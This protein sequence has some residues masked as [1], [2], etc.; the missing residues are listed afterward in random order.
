MSVRTGSIS[1]SSVHFVCFLQRMH[2]NENSLLLTKGK[3]LTAFSSVS[4]I[5]EQRNAAWIGN[6]I[7]Y[8]VTRRFGARSSPEA[9]TTFMKTWSGSCESNYWSDLIP[10]QDVSYCTWPFSYMNT[11]FT[12]ISLCISLIN[13]TSCDLAHVYS[14]KNFFPEFIRVSSG[15]LPK[16]CEV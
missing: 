14:F 10:Q 4:V 2:A 11:Q 1:Q 12:A 7:I 8:L 16:G 3:D 9:T 13:S 15:I 6:R 5:H